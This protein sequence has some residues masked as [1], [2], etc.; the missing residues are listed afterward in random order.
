MQPVCLVNKNNGRHIVHWRWSLLFGEFN[1]QFY[2]N[3]KK[4]VDVHFLMRIE[5]I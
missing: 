5:S 4:K 3:L 2:I 1:S